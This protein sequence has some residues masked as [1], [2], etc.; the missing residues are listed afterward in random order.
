MEMEKEV[1]AN[2]QIRADLSVLTAND[3]FDHTVLEPYWEW[4]HQ[5]NAVAAIEID[6]EAQ[7]ASIHNGK[8]TAVV[9]Q[10]WWDTPGRISFYNEKGEFGRFPHLEHCSGLSVLDSVVGHCAR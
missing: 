7:T 4:N 1:R 8:L 6:H 9:K 3:D 10:S 2:G 5:P